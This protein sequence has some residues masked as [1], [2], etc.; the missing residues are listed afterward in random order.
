MTQLPQTIEAEALAYAKQ[1]IIEFRQQNSTT[2]GAPYSWLTQQA[3][4]ALARQL[5]KSK[6]LWHP[7]DM[8]WVIALARAGWKDADEALRELANEYI[9]V[10]KLPPVPLANYVMELNAGTI[11]PPAR[12]KASNFLRNV[13][14]LMI[15]DER[16]ARNSICDRPG[17][18]RLDRRFGGRVPASSWP[19]RSR[20]NFPTMSSSRARGES[21]K[22]TKT[23][24][25][26]CKQPF[27]FRPKISSTNIGDG[28]PIKM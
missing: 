15:V 1:R 14:I 3:G 25:T 11:H 26:R 4:H 23:C 12:Q 13:V 18:A 19:R 16:S 27:I 6:A 24:A 8:L 2:F 7:N 21:S 28:K 10:Y 5:L 22:S 9:A 20:R 17:A